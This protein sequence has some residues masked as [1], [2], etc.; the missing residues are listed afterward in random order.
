MIWARDVASP[1]E[2]MKKCKCLNENLVRQN[3]LFKC[4]KRSQRCS[5]RLQ[6]EVDFSWTVLYWRVGCRRAT[7]SIALHST[8]LLVS[9]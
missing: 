9:N 2:E 6:K 1:K 3:E 8:L 4:L 5:I 7:D